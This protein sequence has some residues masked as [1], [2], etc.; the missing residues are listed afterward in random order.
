M[1]Q[2]LESSEAA[3]KQ[4]DNTMHRINHLVKLVEK[5]MLKK[6]ELTGMIKTIYLGCAG[7][8]SPSP[9]KNSPVGRARR[10]R[11]AASPETVKV[12]RIVEE[13]VERRFQLQCATVDTK[14]FQA[15]P[16]SSQRRLNEPLFDIAVNDPLDFIY[17][18]NAK[19]LQRVAAS[20]VMHIIKWKVRKMRGNLVTKGVAKPGV[21]HDDGFD[22]QAAAQTAPSQIVVR[23]VRERQYVRVFARDKSPTVN[24]AKSPTAN[25]VK[26]AKS[27]FVPFVPVTKKQTIIMMKCGKC[28]VLAQPFPLDRDWNA[29][30]AIPYCKPCY[31]VL[32]AQM[33]SLAA[34]PKATEKNPKSRKSKGGQKRRKKRVRDE[35]ATIATPPE[36]VCNVNLI[37]RCFSTPS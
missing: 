4:D 19:A 35:E 12:R 13:P 1:P 14:L 27:A 10:Y 37:Y 25:N 31:D 3:G 28:G 22:W 32:D 8:G 2:R 11:R 18:N 34:D 17:V 7:D 5:G 15:Q 26:S 21:Y 30:G 24:N 33:D 6:S 29:D 36:K 20:K 9:K 23:P 16:G